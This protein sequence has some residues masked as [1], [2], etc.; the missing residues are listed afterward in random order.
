M[1]HPVN[2]QR[3]DDKIIGFARIRYVF[4]QPFDPL[5]VR[6]QAIGKGTAKL[7]HTR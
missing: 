3:S 6:Y 5:N 7:D 4:G 2:T 1:V